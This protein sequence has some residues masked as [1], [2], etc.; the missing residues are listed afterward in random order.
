MDHSREFCDALHAEKLK[1]FWNCE[2]RV[3]KIDRDLLNRMKRAGCVRVDFGVESG[4]EE[5]LKKIRK[6]FT[7]EKVRQAFRYCHE[8]KM[9]VQAYFILGTPWETPATIQESISFAKELRPTITAFFLATPYP[10]SELRKEFVN[11]G[12]RVP[13]NYDNYRH[14]TVL[15]P[16]KNQSVG[17]VNSGPQKFFAQECRR[18]TKE[19]I[20]TQLTDVGNYPQLLRSYMRMYSLREFVILALQTLR[21]I[22]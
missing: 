16:S 3:D 1:I 19:I 15:T 7:K 12:W 17:D 21:V 14:A 5:I 13:D 9:P 8:I 6:G 10:G 18:A 20:L 22:L 2:T 11:V 4:N